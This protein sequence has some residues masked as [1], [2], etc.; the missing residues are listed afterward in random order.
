MKKE[1]GIAPM[2]FAEYLRK[3]S[4]LEKTKVY[5]MKGTIY[6]N[7]YNILKSLVATGYLSRLEGGTF[8]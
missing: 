4:V 2:D 7:I 6:K 8:K 5:W 3:S 1:K